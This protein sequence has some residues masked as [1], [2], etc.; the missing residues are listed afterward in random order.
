MSNLKGITEEN[1]AELKLLRPQVGRL[2]NENE[3]LKEMVENAKHNINK[4]MEENNAVK[5][6]LQVSK[7]QHEETLR[8][9]ARKNMESKNEIEKLHSHNQ[10]LNVIYELI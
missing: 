1:I 3:Q 2:T 9:I 5:H 10:Q 7:L 8:T 6:D 4:L